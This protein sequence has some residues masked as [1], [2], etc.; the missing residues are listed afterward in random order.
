[1]CKPR[2]VATG[3]TMEFTLEPKE[4]GDGKKRKE[5]VR[6]TVARVLGNPSTRRDS[7]SEEE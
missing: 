4:T 2:K 7:A 1:M 6:K 3:E 5:R